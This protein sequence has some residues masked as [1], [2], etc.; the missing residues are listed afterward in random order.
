[1][2]TTRDIR[3]TLVAFAIKIAGALLS[4]IFNLTVAR[5]LGPDGVGAF[6]LMVTTLT[7]A[8]TVSLIGLDYVL[9]RVL[10]GDLREGARDS[11]KGAAHAVARLV[12]MNTLVS[13]LFIALVIEP[14]ITHFIGDAVATS[15]LKVTCWGVVPIALIRI[16]SASLRG[17]GRVQVGQL[18]DGPVS[19]ALATGALAF[20]FMW[21][22][23][24]VGLAANLYLATIGLATLVGALISYRD[25]RSWGVARQ[26]SLRPMIAGGWKILVAVLTAVATD[27]LILTGLA[28]YASTSEVG[29]FRT[30]WQVAA[31]FNLLVVAFDAVA[32]PRIAAAWRAG[33]R[34]EIIRSARLSALTMTLLASP[35]LAVC[36]LAPE[37]LL[38]WFG[39]Q[40][41]GGA[42]ALRILAVGQLINLATGPIGSILIMTGHETASM[43][44]G[45][46]AVITALIFV[47]TVVPMFG[48]T[49]AALVSASIL[50]FRKIAGLILVT[51]VIR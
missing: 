18:L 2:N 33:N 47:L 7:L 23:P 17:S 50:A 34:L 42:D 51:K 25:M 28:R 38:H 21:G 8:S 27:W 12:T 24:T 26:I 35:L 4:F 41:V 40:F 5:W 29:L 9:I 22:R 36:L 15:A 13:A 6:G 37:W 14:L 44:N 45:I 1:M 11:A 49:G 46:I 19:S 10:A 43:N 31:L 3:Q 32:G 39:P 30:A 48:L 20:C 16:V